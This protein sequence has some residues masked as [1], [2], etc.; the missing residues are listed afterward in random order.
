MSHPDAAIKA[1][2][3]EDDLLRHVAK[4]ASSAFWSVPRA[5]RW[6]LRCNR[7]YWRCWRSCG[8]GRGHVKERRVLEQLSPMVGAAAKRIILAL[9]GKDIGINFIGAPSEIEFL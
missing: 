6:L 1:I 4:V 7:G 3:I 9:A 2:I 5:L 8:V